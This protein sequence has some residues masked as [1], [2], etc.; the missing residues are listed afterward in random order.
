MK[1]SSTGYLIREGFRNIWSNRMMSLASV[2]VLMSC[3][4]I[5]GAAALISVNV[6]SLI[7][8]IGDD[9]QLTVYLLPE[10]S[11]IDSVKVG[12]KLLEINNVESAKFRSRNDV[13]EDYKDTL[14][15]DIYMA[16]EGSGNPFGNE[17]K[18]KLADLSKYDETVSEISKIE[19]VDS[20]SDRSD[21]ADKLTRLNYFVTIVGIWVVA[22]LGVVTLFIISNTIRMTMFSRRFE[23]S[24]MH[25]VGATNAFIRIP[26]VIE[27]IIIGLISGL[28]ASCVVIAAYEPLR[29]AASSVI[30]MIGSS[31]LPV[32]G[33]WAPTLLLM[34]GIGIVIGLLGG[35]ISISRYLNKEG[36]AVI[37]R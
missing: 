25:S 16:M 36:G 26:F 30:G 8:S 23:I 4:I 24:I 7:A 12:P 14:G 27:A 5:T 31:T 15:E 1:L 29:N 6:N 28:L 10:Y 34:S 13:L 3:L 21:I 35:T 19:G 9:D 20:V 17:Y 37:G 2:V 33:I 22:V 11:D 18:V 32:D